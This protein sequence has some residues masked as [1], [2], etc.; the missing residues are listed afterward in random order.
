M[1]QE[2]KRIT[3]KGRQYRTKK[4]VKFADR[5]AGV[6]IST[7]GVF[8]I[9]AVTGVFVFLAA[10]VVPL[11]MP[12]QVE[13]WRELP[14]KVGEEEEVILPSSENV[15]ATDEYLVAGW[16]AE[17]GGEVARSFRL[18]NG[19]TL[20]RQDIFGGRRPRVLSFSP[21]DELV[22]AAFGDG[23]VQMAKVGFESEFLFNEEE[24]PPR[25]LE[26]T[27][28]EVAS[29]QGGMVQLTPAGLRWQK[30]VVEP[31]TPV[32]VGAEELRLLDVSMLS[33]GPVVATLD[34]QR[35]FRIQKFSKRRNLLTGKV[36]ITPSGGSMTI[37]RREEGLPSGLL[38]SGRA[39]IAYLTWPDG[40][41]LRL[42]TRDINKPQIA[43][44]LSL[45]PD[46]EARLTAIS[47]LIGKT[48][49]VSGDSTGRV[50]AWFTTKP[51]DAS[52]V[53]GAVLTMVHD[54]GPGPAAVTSF[55][56]S[57]R[58]RLLA[59]GFADG[60]VRLNH[61]TSSQVL[62]DI[63][64]SKVLGGEEPI[65][66]LSISPKDNA[67]A[68]LTSAGV[69]LWRVDAKHPAATLQTLFGKVHYEGMNEPGHIWQ[70][71]SGTDE[72][73]PKYGLVPLI[74]GTLKGTFYSM[75]F[76]VPLAL[77][78]AVYTSEFMNR[79]LRARIKPLVELMESLPTVVLGF[80]AA[81]IF[82]VF[83]EG[84]VADVL[85]CF[86]T[87][88]A[89]F[90][91]AAYLFQLLPVELFVRL[92]RWRF[93]M[94]FF[95]AM[96]VGVLLA[97]LVGPLLE[98]VLFAGDI[99]AWLAG[100]V[101]SGIGGWFLMFVPLAALAVVFGVTTWVNPWL[102][103]RTFHLNRLQA[104][105]LEVAKMVVG[106]AAVVLLAWLAAWLLTAIGFDSRGDFPL[107]GPVLGDYV[108]R[109]ALVVGFVMGFAII[110]AVY[111]LAEDALSSVPEHL[112][113]GSLAAGATPWQTATRII[114]PTAA[115]GLFSAVM[116]GLGRAVGETM[117]VLMATGN[118]PVLEWNIFNGFRTLSAN[119]AV[120]LPEAV[121][122]G[123]HFRV[124]FL[125][126]LTLF[127]MTFVVNT[128]AEVI[129]QRFRKR[130]FEL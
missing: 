20:A 51:K 64:G 42:D 104:G 115:S 124:L 40:H 19:Q 3:G 16:E 39:D 127:L 67:M 26:L 22:A 129:R 82:A 103:E 71:S 18:D 113:S 108:Q 63:P 76:G 105:L 23:T 117:I 10:I 62:A 106:M 91:G 1:N 118:T 125:A 24:L 107:I 83:V 60:T 29:Y 44:E 126:A 77:L 90:V 120:E 56:A 110:P 123:T 111:T 78:A 58:S 69:S 116:L 2:T 65:R 15:L 128:M 66:A 36:T 75:L 52:T 96:P 74:F 11:F 48:T 9:L 57:M 46:G 34:D 12:A 38:L 130:A 32:E 100:R 41:L 121:V 93:Y 33:S 28:D 99:M 13:P 5:V 4:S 47:F 89:A 101:G 79:G 70:S 53:D 35:T 25:L 27:G 81:L 92:S 86:F 49:L 6:L 61:I 87:V 73:E 54:L 112:R 14:F 102:R 114:I 80:L 98:T 30:L 31:Q 95:L 85:A 7:G 119:I 21:R 55:S 72:F 17:K 84:R 8:T 97:G 94:L 122:F 59:V 109:N 50:R 68:A 37:P 43:E 88:P 45:I